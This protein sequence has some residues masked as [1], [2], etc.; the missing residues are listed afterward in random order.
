MIHLMKIAFYYYET[1]S[2]GTIEDD[3]VMPTTHY[4]D[5]DYGDNDTSYDLENLFGNNL[6]KYDNND[7]YTI[8]AIHA[9]D[10]ESDYLEEIAN[11]ME[12]YKL[13]DDGCEN[14]FASEN[15]DDMFEN[16]FATNYA[17][18]LDL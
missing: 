4:D 9:I 2:V 14:P 17:Y 18:P 15:E 13:G 11:D 1:M 5:Y 12:N 8:G 10:D 6:E 7:C 16:I 3:F